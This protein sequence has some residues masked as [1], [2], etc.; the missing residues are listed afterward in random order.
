MAEASIRFPPN[1]NLEVPPW[2][3]FF[4]IFASIG[5]ITLAVGTITFQRLNPKSRY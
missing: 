5:N 4:L 1:V 2:L 3:S